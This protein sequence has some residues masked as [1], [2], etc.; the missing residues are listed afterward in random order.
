MYTTF[1]TNEM[2]E[3]VNTEIQHTFETCIA[4]VDT[5][6][7]MTTN[8]NVFREKSEHEISEFVMYCDGVIRT[9]EMMKIDVRSQRNTIGILRARAEKHMNKYL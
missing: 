4:W 9:L 5:Y 1:N 3:K 2:I 6:A 8:S 7:E